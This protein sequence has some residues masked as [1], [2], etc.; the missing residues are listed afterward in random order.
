MI[1][2]DIEIKKGILGKNE[3]RHPD[4][5]YCKG[6]ND[7]QAMGISVICAYDYGENRYRVFC[8]DNMP[9]FQGL[10]N[11]HNVIV[12]FNNI[13][14]DN[15]VCKANGI[16]V[17]EDKS[18]D[19]LREIW[20]AAGLGPV[21]RYPSHLGYG[22]DAVVKANFPQYGKTGHGAMAPVQWQRGQIGAVIDY[23]ASDVWLTKLLMDMVLAGK[24]IKCPKTGEPLAIEPPNQ[25]MIGAL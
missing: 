12:G 23:C 14:F 1:V 24:P 11:R 19:L 16:V 10:V 7:H 25:E 4:I 6:W 3:T 18:F 15:Q 17:P 5:E 22:L 9:G 21:F 8:A 2:F 13:S 20:K